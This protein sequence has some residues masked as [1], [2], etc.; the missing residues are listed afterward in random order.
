MYEIDLSTNETF[1]K[2]REV[3]DLLNISRA[4]VYRLVETGDLKALRINQA[5]RIRQSDL[6]EYIQEHLTSKV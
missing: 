2:V 5:I 6:E 4:L 3:Q 1:L